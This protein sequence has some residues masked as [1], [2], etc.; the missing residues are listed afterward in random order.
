MRL[1]LKKSSKEKKN[2]LK[3]EYAKE[4]ARADAMIKIFIQ[5]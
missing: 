5:I 1:F 3:M 4:R 2:L